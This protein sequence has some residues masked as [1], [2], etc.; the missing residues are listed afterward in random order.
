MKI[1][2]K[3]F[4]NGDSVLMHSKGV[5]SWAIRG[6][7]C[8]WWNHYGYY[9][10]G[11]VIEARGKGVVKTSIDVYI[12]NPKFDLGIFRV[13]ESAFASKQEYEQAIII[14]SNYAE[15]QVGKPYDKNAI[16]WLGIRYL[17]RGFLRWLIPQRYNP[18][19]SRLEFFCSELGCESWW[20]TSSIVKNL[21]A[22]LKYLLATCGTITPKDIGKSVHSEWVMGTNKI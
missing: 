16:L 3:S 6:V 19:Q 10:D 12:N 11:F 17:T 22:G 13:K 2:I 14:S 8:S 7:T 4:R 5:G 9:K 1:S 15:A 21:F 20:M 18:W